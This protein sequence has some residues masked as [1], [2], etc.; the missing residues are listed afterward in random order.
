MAKVALDA[1]VIIGW[2]D[3]GDSLNARSAKLIERIHDASR[4]APESTRITRV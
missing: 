2:L 1:N 4:T 3:E